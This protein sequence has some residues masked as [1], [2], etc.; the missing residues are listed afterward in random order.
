MNGWR[1]PRRK[2]PSCAAICCASRRSTTAGERARER[3]AAEYVAGKLAEVG[4]EP[5]ILES[6][7]G[8]TSLVAR[9]EGEDPSRG[10]LLIHGHL[11]VVPADAADWAVHPFSGEISDDGCIWGRGAV[12]MKDMDAMM[13]AVVRERLRTG[14]KPPRDIVLAFLA[15]EEAGGVYGA[16]WLVEN[17]PRPVRG[18]HRGDRRGRR[19]LLTKSA[20][21]C[22][23]TASRRRRR[24]S[25]WMRLTVAGRAGH[26]S[27]VAHDNAVTALCEAV[28]R[29]GRHTFPGPADAHRSHLPGGAERRARRA[30]RPREPRSRGRAARRLARLVGATLRN[31]ANPSH[32]RGRLQGQ[33]H[34]RDRQRRRRR[35]LPARR[36]KPTSRRRW[37]P[38]SAPTSNASGSTSTT[39][40]RPASTAN[41]STR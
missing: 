24:A 10:A 40:S 2:L 17:H 39:A 8:R 1:A 18:L 36:E 26:G 29:L 14:R 12:D 13:L 21:T 11:D 28:A 25:A 41:W 34:S 4:I 33:R 37:T 30:A 31:T 35:A 19:V 20:M 15:D 16:R 27:M 38:S 23:S 5:T 7:P 22:G 3:D 32:A 9:I 6:K